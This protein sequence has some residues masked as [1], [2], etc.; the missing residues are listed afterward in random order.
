MADGLQ[1]EV[2]EPY[3]SRTRQVGAETEVRGALRDVEFDAA[4]LPRR[5]VEEGPVGQAEPITAMATVE[6][7]S[8]GA[9]RS[10]PHDARPMPSQGCVRSTEGSFSPW[11]KGRTPEDRRLFLSLYRTTLVTAPRLT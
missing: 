7:R 11:R 4:V 5:G 2:G 10:H 9:V 8:E 1:P 3:G 6:A